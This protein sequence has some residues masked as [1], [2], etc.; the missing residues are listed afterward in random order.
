M[1]WDLYLNFLAAMFAIVNPIGILPI[2]SELTSDKPNQIRKR[3]AFLV[4]GT[5]L[6]ILLMFL[7]AGGPILKF[8]SIDLSVFK[9]AGGILLLFTG[10]SMVQGSATQITN[11]EEEGESSLEV[12]KK[13]FRKILVPMA[14]PTLAGPG[15][16]TTVIL[17]GAKIDGT[18]DFLAFGIVILLAMVT[19]FFIF[20]FTAPVEGKVDGMIFSVVTRVFGIIVTAIAIQFVVE[21]LGD[22]FPN[23]LEGNSTLEDGKVRKENSN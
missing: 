20:S 16:I 14:I 8:F 3:V 5:S 21:G 13:R 17:F 23:W 9:I 2:W 19:L 4:T 22:V 18:I 12:A 10:I 7:F 6:L 1:S 11:R 15:S